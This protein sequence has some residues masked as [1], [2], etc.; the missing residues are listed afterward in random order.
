MA[1]N[2][3]RLEPEFSAER[4]TGP[5][6]CPGPGLI[7]HARGSL[8]DLQAA[9]LSSTRRSRRGV[10]RV[11]ECSD[12]TPCRRG[13][14]GVVGGFS[15]ARFHCTKTITHAVVAGHRTSSRPAPSGL[16]IVLVQ[17]MRACT[18]GNRL[19]L[20]YRRPGT[21]LY[22]R[23]KAAGSPT[24]VREAAGCYGTTSI[25]ASRRAD[26]AACERGRF[27]LGGAVQGL[28]LPSVTSPARTC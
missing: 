1:S 10:D 24:K 6:T 12:R 4:I 11:V 19:S 17:T 21:W 15:P 22:G 25:G 20:T 28:E 16:P 27:Y 14:A 9:P 8:V 5:L 18:V 23:S 3:R 26:D 7:T 2:P 13:A